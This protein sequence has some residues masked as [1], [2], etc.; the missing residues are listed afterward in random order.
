VDYIEKVANKDIAAFE[1]KYRG[2]ALSRGAS[3]FVN[4]YNTA[5]K[6]ITK[7][8]YFEFISA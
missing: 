1:F 4:E 6:L 8:N 5:V 3:S 2:N 7:E